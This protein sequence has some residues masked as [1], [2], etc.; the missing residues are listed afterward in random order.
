QGAVIR[1]VVSRLGDKRTFMIGLTCAAVGLF[2]A[3]AALSVTA[4]MIALVPLAFG[5]GFG[6]PT[7]ASLV[8]QTGRGNE[9]GRVQGAA[10]ALESMGR[11]IGPVWGNAS[12]QHWSDATPY[13]SAGILVLLTLLMSVGFSV[14]DADAVAET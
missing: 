9:Q 14:S 2:S 5:L 4:L 6:H 3:A 12:L 11:A 1:P 8:S 7:V 13:I 10:G